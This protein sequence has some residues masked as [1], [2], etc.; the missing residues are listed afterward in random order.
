MNT[1][2]TNER[3]LLGFDEH[4]ATTLYVYKVILQSVKRIHPTQI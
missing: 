4:L 2:I 3:E 1:P